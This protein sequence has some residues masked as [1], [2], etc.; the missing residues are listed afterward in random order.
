MKFFPF[1]ILSI[2]INYSYK[3]QAS[4]NL[5][6]KASFFSQSLAAASR[7]NKFSTKTSSKYQQPTEALFTVLLYSSLSFYIPYK[8]VS[9]VYPVVREKFSDPS[10]IESNSD[11]ILTEEDRRWIEFLSTNH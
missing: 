10:F 4:F 8:I 6:R 2:C 11:Y 1:I 7:V 9:C 5:I 3:S